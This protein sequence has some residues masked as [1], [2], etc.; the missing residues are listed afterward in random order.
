MASKKRLGRG[1]DALLGPKKAAAEDAKVEVPVQNNNSDLM[2]L[3]VEWIVRGKYQP[4]KE[5]DQEKLEELAA[6][7]NHQGLIQPIVVRQ[8]ESERYEIIAGE[9]RWLFGPK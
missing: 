2:T 9:R 1:L 4:R 8:L 7:I 3:P 5:F 6:S